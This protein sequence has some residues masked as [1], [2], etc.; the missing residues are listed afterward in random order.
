MYKRTIPT[1]TDLNVN[2]SYP[3]EPLP[4]TIAR[5]VNNG[6]PIGQQ[7]VPIVYEERK[8]GVDPD[9]NIRTDKW[10][11]AA[12]AMDKAAEQRLKAREAR[13]EAREKGPEKLPEIG[14]KDSAQGAEGAA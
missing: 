10:E 14:G 5:L 7:T 6:E 9:C 4:K 1:K 8:A 13:R 11:H 3:A 12:E 2:Q